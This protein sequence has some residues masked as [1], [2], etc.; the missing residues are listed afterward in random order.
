MSEDDI[1]PFTGYFV[2]KIQECSKKIDDNNKLEVFVILYFNPIKLI[3]SSKAIEGYYIERFNIE[4]ANLFCHKQTYY[5]FLLKNLKPYF[6]NFNT[7][8]NSINYDSN[9]LRSVLIDVYNLFLNITL[10]PKNI[11]I[12]KNFDFIQKI[13]KKYL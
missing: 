6:N 7:I 9:C 4:Y 2:S 10:H 3:T 12:K 5:E 1:L 11:Y 8:I 13:I